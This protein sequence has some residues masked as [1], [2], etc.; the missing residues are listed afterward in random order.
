MGSGGKKIISDHFT[1]FSLKLDFFLGGRRGASKTPAGTMSGARDMRSEGCGA[2]RRRRD[3]RLRSW[4]RHEQQSIMAAVTTAWHRS[5]DGGPRCASVATQTTDFFAMNIS[6]IY[7]EGF[8]SPVP[9]TEYVTLAPADTYTELSPVIEHVTPAPVDVY[10][11]PARV[12]DHVA[13]SLEI[14][15]IAPP[16]AETGV[17]LNLDTTSF[18]NSQFS[19]F[20]VEASA[21]QVVGSFPAVEQIAAEQESL[22]RAQQRT[23]EH[24]V[25]VSIPQIQEQFV[26]GVKEIPRKRLPE[27]VVE[28]I[29]NTPIPQRVEQIAE[30]NVHVS[31]L[32]IQDRSQQSTSN[33]RIR[34]FALPHAVLCS[35]SAICRVFD[36]EP[37]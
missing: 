23:V 14:D 20:A 29:E 1:V 36:E 18:V 11:A 32:Q 24:I 17:F 5:R 31:I 27:R 21:S 16:S 15:Y 37:H 30:Q 12:I 35:M 2:A 22:E 19:I 4:W 9:V 25:H 28:Q 8:A 7:D 6:D 33:L 10:T 34:P 3:R 26:E 13:P